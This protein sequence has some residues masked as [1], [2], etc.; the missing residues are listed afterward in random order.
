MEKTSEILDK[1]G[2][3][4]GMTVPE[5]YFADFAARMT[6]ALPPLPQAQPQ[7]RTFWHRV[8]PYVYMAAMFAGI[9][10]MMQMFGMMQSRNV[11]LSIE[12]YPGVA[13]ALSDE[14]FVK[15]CIYPE[16]DQSQLLD[17]LYDAGLSPEEILYFDD[18]ETDAGH[19]INPDEDPLYNH[20]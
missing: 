9:W 5:G 2:R 8:R 4:S 17:D 13:T 16:L 20:Q 12:N 19:S 10:L 18:E 7:R 14:G 15:E 6:E 11:D 3:R 1:V